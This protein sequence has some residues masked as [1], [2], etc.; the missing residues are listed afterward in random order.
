MALAHP[1]LL[2]KTADQERRRPAAPEATF[3]RK[4]RGGNRKAG[5]ILLHHRSF[6]VIQAR[7]I[8]LVPDGVA[9]PLLISLKAQ[10]GKVYEKVQRSFR[11]HAFIGSNVR[12]GQPQGC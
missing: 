3:R 5:L 9:M 8:I 12:T 11:L 10:T 1:H 6:S 7:R 4:D 2:E